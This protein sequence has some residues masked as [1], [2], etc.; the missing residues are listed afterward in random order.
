MSDYDASQYPAAPIVPVRILNP[1]TG[2]AITLKGLIDSGAA[3]SV[4]P[5]ETTRQLGLKPVDEAQVRGFDVSS[6]TVP[7]FRSTWI[8]AEHVLIGVE[9]VAVERQGLLLGRDVLQHFILTLNGKTETFEL[10]DP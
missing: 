4:V 6:S 8:I 9:H 3:I 10:V 7:V 2:Q 1:T 5:L